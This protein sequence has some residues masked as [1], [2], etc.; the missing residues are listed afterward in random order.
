MAPLLL[1]VR[2]L[3]IGWLPGAVLFRM[4]VLER[5]RRAALPA[6]ERAYW[7]IV[8]SVTTSI[9]LVLAMAALHRYSFTRLIVAEV[10]LSAVLVASA[11]VNLRLGAAARAWGPALVVPLVLIAVAAWRFTPPFEYIIGGKDPGVYLNEGIQIAQRGALVVHDPV[12]AAVPN[13]ARDLFMPTDRAADEYLAPRF[14]GFYVLDPGTGAVVGQFPHVF[15]ASVAIGY[16][17]AGLTG[18]RYTV[19]C[20]SMLGVL[21]VYF[22]GARLVDR[23]AAAAAALLLSLNVIQVWFAR[24]PNTDIVMQALLFAALLATAR[25]HVD[26]DPFF[27]PLAGTLCALLLFLRLDAV[28]A[29][30]AVSAGVALG[31]AA[32]QRPRW[33][34]WPPIA[35]GAVLAVWYYQRLMW[36]YIEVPWRFLGR[37][38]AWQFAA[39]AALG[40]VIVVL[41]LISRRSAAA[42]QAVRTHLPS[43]LTLAVSALACYALLFRVPGGKL[44]DYDAFA[45]RTFAYFYL[46]VPAL[47]AAV[48]GYALI[49]RARF[50]RDPAFFVTLTAFS[51]FFFYKI[52][53]VPEHFWAARRFLAIILPGALLLA[54]AA[55]LTG[56][57]GRLLFTRAIR[58]P[59]GIVFLALLAVSYARAAK[60]VVQHVEYAGVIARLEALAA[61]VHD[62]DLLLV[63]ARDAGS[64]VHVLATPLAY[65][66]ARNVLLLATAVPDKPTFAAFLD[67]ARRRY[68]RVLFLG[69]GGTDLLSSHWSVTP[70]VSERFQVPEYDAPRNAYPRFVREK[71]FDYSV[72]AFGPAVSLPS[73]DLDVGVNDDLNVIRFHAKESS[74][75]V[76]YRWSQGQS[77]IVLNR[78]AASDRTIAL[79]LHDGG[80]PAAA[81]AADLTLM[82]GERVLDTIRV[83]GPAFREY[84]API[85][86]E[87]ASKLATGEPVR[88]TLRVPTWNPQAMLGGSDAREL[89]VMVDRVALR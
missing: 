53:I 16:G 65:I 56:V 69:G 84:D 66:Y 11:R 47:V 19:V 67:D 85:P 26:E 27:A 79:W 37:V 51:L 31:Y 28:L 63:E 86:A 54:A 21:S 6:E 15:P 57:R 1:L 83:S 60:P 30:G 34:F 77:F 23:P 5:D 81:P 78:V 49:A 40:G 82:I 45:L 75:G 36:P 18:A 50:W 76:S 4:P 73:V 72:Y 38:P 33:S 17:L 10:L 74:G 14:M 25:A 39:I 9:V 46:T 3:I 89:G 2:A 24:Y 44:T 71:E 62:D 29:V 80:R 59:I 22:L 42:V 64:D 41:I 12:V 88:L 68:R 35:L 70:I 87:L 20:W 55:A 32:G 7:A 52:R 43:V 13:F 58:G 8:L 48:V 61:Q